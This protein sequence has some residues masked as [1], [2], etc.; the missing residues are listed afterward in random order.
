MK[1]ET[2]KARQQNL[3]LVMEGVDKIRL[4]FGLDTSQMIQLGCAIIDYVKDNFPG[5]EKN[6]DTEVL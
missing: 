2:L 3:H 6:I 1:V 4:G 5:K